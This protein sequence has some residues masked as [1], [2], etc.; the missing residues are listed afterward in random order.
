MTLI[1]TSAMLRL[2]F[3]SLVLGITP[4]KRTHRPL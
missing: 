4:Q 2:P 1:A 3:F